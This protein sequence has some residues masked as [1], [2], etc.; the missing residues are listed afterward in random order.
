MF[1][2]INGTQYELKFGFKFL[3]ALDELTA[4]QEKTPGLTPL[5]NAVLQLGVGDIS[6]APMIAQAALSHH[7]QIPEAGAVEDALEAM[8]DGLKKG[9]TICSVFISALKKAPLHTSQVTKMADLAAK[10]SEMQSQMMS[11]SMSEL[12]GRL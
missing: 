12:E 4:D 10:M 9:E 6:M 3:K 5:D 11:K 7:A 8:A 2:T 1:L